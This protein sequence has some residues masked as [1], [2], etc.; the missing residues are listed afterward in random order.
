MEQDQ[1]VKEREPE[2]EWAAEAEEEWEVIDRV[3]AREEIVSAPLAE[4]PS[5]IR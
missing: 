2:E 4:Q 1:E 5:L 3:P